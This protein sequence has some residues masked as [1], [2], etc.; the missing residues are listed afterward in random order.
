MVQGGGDLGGGHPLGFFVDQGFQGVDVDGAV[1]QFRLAAF[2][3]EHVDQ[4]G[5]VAGAAGPGEFGDGLD[6]QGLDVGDQFFGG[7]DEVDQRCGWELPGLGGGDRIEGGRVGGGRRRVGSSPLLSTPYRRQIGD[8]S[9]V[10][11]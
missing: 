4:V 7:D 3:G 11:V 2:F 9:C 8:R 5:Q 6:L 1:G 10:R